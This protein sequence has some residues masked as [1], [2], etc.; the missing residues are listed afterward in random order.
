V[1][2]NFS[3]AFFHI[4]KLAEPAGSSEEQS[5]NREQGKPRPRVLAS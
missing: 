1:C 3:E 5:Q 2:T 4:Q